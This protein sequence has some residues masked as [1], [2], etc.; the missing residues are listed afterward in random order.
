M[1][2]RQLT[3]HLP[4]PRSTT[5]LVQESIVNGLPHILDW[6]F[7]CGR[8]EDFILPGRRLGCRQHPNLSTTNFLFVNGNG[9]CDVGGLSGH[10]I[11][12]GSLKVQELE[13][14]VGQRVHLVGHRRQTLRRVPFRLINCFSLVVHLQSI[15]LSH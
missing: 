9:L 12:L 4:I 11:E 6:L 5:N 13:K 15:I 8:G 10:F 7:W 3:Q 14:V 2:A 1:K